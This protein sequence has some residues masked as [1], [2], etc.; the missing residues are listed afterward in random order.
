MPTAAT[1]ATT[2][3]TATTAAATTT[4]AATTAF[5]FRTAPAP[6]QL[7]L[8]L[9][10]VDLLDIDRCVLQEPSHGRLPPR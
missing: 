8:K 3:T 1:E 5:A 6:Q 7:L 2:A 9:G 10:C 4:E